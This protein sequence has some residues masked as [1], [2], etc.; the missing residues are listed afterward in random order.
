M[1]AAVNDANNIVVAGTGTVYTAPATS[2]G[3][4]LPVDVATAMNAAFKD[5]GLTTEDGVTRTDGKA[6]DDVATWQGFYPARR[7]VTG[8]SGSLSVVMR[9]YHPEPVALAFGGGTV[10]T[11]TGPPAYAVY[12][13]PAPE[14]IVYKAVVIEYLDGTDKFRFVIPRA[15]VTGDVESNLT[16]TAAL[17]LP[18]TL[19]MVPLGRPSST[20]SA[21]PTA[22]QLN[23]FA[24]YEV[25]NKLSFTTP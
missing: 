3:S 14:A 12:T 24:W 6:V 25:S 1:P 2:N 7:I 5:A 23:T 10:T 17:E 15:M 8:K 16:R 13:P 4:T 21:P 18:V 19:D 9:E 20:L 22:A 11:V